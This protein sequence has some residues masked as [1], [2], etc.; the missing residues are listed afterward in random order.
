MHQ[1]NNTHAPHLGIRRMLPHISL[2]AK[3]E[4]LY[5]Q[6]LCVYY[7]SGAFLFT[8]AKRKLP[9]DGSFYKKSLVKVESKKKEKKNWTLM[10]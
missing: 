8:P 9:N 4:V 7:V 2:T 5:M 6:Q 1:P 3:V 10:G